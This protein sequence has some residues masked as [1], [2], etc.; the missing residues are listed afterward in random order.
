MEAGGSSDHDELSR[1]T[2]VAARVQED[3]CESSCDW[4]HHWNNSEADGSSV[5]K[6]VVCTD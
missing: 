2:A 3:S 1:H 4:N 6:V 5:G